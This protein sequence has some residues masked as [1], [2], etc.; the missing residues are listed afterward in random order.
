[1]T[2]R[3]SRPLTLAV[4]LTAGVSTLSACMAQ[5][6]DDN[7][8]DRRLRLALN[9]VPHAELSPYTDDAVSLARMGVI[10]SLITFDQDGTPQPALA[11]K[12]EM[13]DPRTAT[14]T[15]RQG[16]SFHDGTA[17]DAAAVANALNHALKASP[18]PATVSGRKLT[19]S[20]EGDHT[21]KVVSA[22]P[23]PILVQRFG[24]PDMAILA[25][26]AYQKNPNQPSAIDAA[27]GPFELVS[28]TGTSAA[29]ADANPAYWGGKPRLPGLDVSFVGKG[30]SRVSGL[31]S[32]EYDV[33]QN[34]PIAQ[35]SNI[36]EQVVDTHPIPR[37]TGLSLNTKTGPLTD[38]GL[39]VAVAK[40]ID[41]QAIATSVFEGQADPA[42]GYFRGD[43][44]WTKDRPDPVYPSAKDPVGTTVT[45]ATYGDRPELPE[46]ATL[47]AEQLRSAGFTVNAPIVKSYA[48]LEPELL[49]GTY[50]I[51]I[52]SRMYMSKAN[53]PLSLLQ[54]DFGC[55][56]TYNLAHYCDAAFDADLDKA[57]QLTDLTAR[58]KAA[59]EGET[60]VLGAGVYVP[61]IHEVERVG[62]VKAVADL[63]PDPLGW[64]MV[65]AQTSFSS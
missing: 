12:F 40:A 33:I 29:K 17:M 25:A 23:D 46:A 59:V 19:I 11:E 35:V 50:D 36:T 18:A 15:L 58:R 10:E 27:T 16:V 60:K 14:F 7:S 37:T 64:R 22:T 30:D 9:F 52:G 63:S 62:R 51:V 28:L 54:S 4:I 5:P 65:T 26:K 20:T 44:A 34:V 57:A 55:A 2:S 1:M 45:I 43:T 8:T 53:D 13:S 61:L 38:V 39:R 42:A 32:G 31:R 6:A 21:V 24:N 56:G 49:A 3:P 47:V 41:R 48:V